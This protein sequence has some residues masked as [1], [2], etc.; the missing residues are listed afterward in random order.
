MT[1]NIGLKKWA[2]IK[3]Q[4]KFLNEWTYGQ[5]FE[6]VA[7][8]AQDLQAPLAN[9]KRVA[10][11]SEN[12]P[13]MAFVLLAL[14]H[15]DKEVLLL[16]TAL[17]ARELAEQLSEL[18]VEVLITSQAQAKTPSVLMT[19][20]ESLIFAPL[21]AADKSITIFDSSVKKI[22]SAKLFDETVKNQIDFDRAFDPEKIAVIMNTSATTGKFKSVPITWG[23]I[24]AQV[25][26]S[27]EVVGVTP[28][29]NW[30]IVLPMFHVSGLSVL[31]RTLYNGTAAT[32]LPHFDEKVVLELI[33]ENR[34]NMMSLVPTML[35]RMLPDLERHS[36]RMILLGGAFIPQPLMAASLA[37]NLP[38]YKTYGMTETFSQSATF[39]ILQ[40]PDKLEAVGKALPG[41]EI[42]IEQP[43]SAGAGEIFLTSPMLMTGYLGQPALENHWL[44]TGDIGYLDGDGYLYV[45]N[46]RKDII[47]SGG[48]NI[49]PK[50]IENLLYAMP[51]MREVALV[52]RADKV[53]GQVPALYFAADRKISEAEI[54]TY[55]SGKIAKYKLPKAVIQLPELPKNASGK[56]VKKDLK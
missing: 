13:A 19:T 2:E 8:A 28:A 54:L 20:I 4:A 18:S 34:I 35:G 7:Q 22:S 49:Y 29:D 44:A 23:M 11:L 15:L 12:S 42:T 50:E 46:R 36:L 14:L 37:K 17:T 6:L 1:S 53:W 5:S 27:A 16:N 3:P 56:I 26:A 39:N 40:A 55:L 24:L 33:A 51:G 48:E 9:V 45:L 32:I 31:M 52:P 10:L 41:V 30:L 21:T 38:I 25:Q 43:D 47:I